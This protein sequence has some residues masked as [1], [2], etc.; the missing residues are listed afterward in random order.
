V[1]LCSVDVDI[2]AVRRSKFCKLLRILKLKKSNSNKLKKR[3]SNPNLKRR[4]HKYKLKVSLYCCPHSCTCD[5]NQP[6][7]QQNVNLKS[8]NNANKLF[9]L[10]H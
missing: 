2:F 3:R 1:L 5:W 6:T 4:S 10:I 9:H 8:D 7:Q